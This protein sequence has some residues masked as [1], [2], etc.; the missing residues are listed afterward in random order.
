MGYIGNMTYQEA[1]DLAGEAGPEAVILGHFDMFAENSADP[2]EFAD[3]LDAKYGSKV[4]CIIPK[5]LED[6]VFPG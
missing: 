3:Y 5:T 2:E 1:V 4:R 6:I